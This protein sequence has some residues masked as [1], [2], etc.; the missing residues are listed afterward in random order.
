[1]AIRIEDKAA[2]TVVGLRVAALTRKPSLRA[3]N[4]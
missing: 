1:M 4:G 2:E 3:A